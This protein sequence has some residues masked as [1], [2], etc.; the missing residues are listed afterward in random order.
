M[1][2]RYLY[3]S[4]AGFCIILSYL[5]DKLSVW[6]VWLPRFFPASVVLGLVCLYV[7]TTYSR[8]L[9]WKNQ[10]VFWSVTKEK[11]PSS[12]MAT[13][14]LGYAFYQEGEVNKAV[15]YYLEVLA[16]EHNDYVNIHRDLARAYEDLGNTKLAEQEYSTAT[17][18]QKQ[19]T[20]K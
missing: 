20:L 11:Y 4:S 5:V 9:E 19:K 15:N 3:L 12:A 17:A 16:L 13:H 18:L 6:F 7:F 10:I 14:N 8:N 1:G 2:E